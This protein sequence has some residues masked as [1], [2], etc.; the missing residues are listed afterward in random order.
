MAK[1]S[2]R[3]PRTYSPV[4]DRRVLLSSGG[5][6]LL[7]A[8]AI[9]LWAYFGTSQTTGVMRLLAFMRSTF[10]W[11][12]YLVPVVL[13]VLGGLLLQQTSKRPWRWPWLALTG[14]F[15]VILAALALTHLLAD[16][17]TVH[18]TTSKGGVIGCLLGQGLQVLIGKVVAVII[19]L[20]VA[21]AG[22]LMILR[23]PL[24]SV[25]SLAG[26]LIT[27]GGSAG[28]RLAG[29]VAVQVAKLKQSRANKPTVLPPATEALV[30][31]QPKIV[32]APKPAATP[33]K[34]SATPEEPLIQPEGSAPTRN[35]VL[36]VMQQMLMV[37]QDSQMSLADI[38]DK[39]RIIETTLGSLG[40]PAAVTEVNPGPVVTQFGIEPG[41]I[42]RYDRDGKL[43]RSKVKIS[44]IAA[45]SNDLALA[46]AASPI[47]IEAPVPGKSIVGLE[48]P[49]GRL[50]TVGLRGVLESP[51]FAA[52]DSR[53]AM[54]LGRDVSGTAVVADL[55]KLP[56]L[57][58]AGATGSGK[59]VCLNAIIVSLLL[60]NTPDQLKLILVD[61]KRVELTP[62]GGIPHLLSPVVVEP[63]RV[64]GVLNWLMREMDSRY[65]NF[66]AAGAR[67]IEAYNESAAR[68]GEQKLPFIVLI[69]DELADLMIVAPDEVERAVCRLAQMARATGIHLI[70]AT[71][72]P[73]VDVVTGLIKA[74]FPARIAFAVTSQVDSRVILDTPGA[75]KLLGRGD[76]LV[77]APNSPGLT[78]IQGC[79]VSDGELSS[80]VEFWCAQA[81]PTSP[82]LVFD[83]TG[84]T[85]TQPPL[86]ELDARDEEPPDSAMLV[87]AREVVQRSGKAS[88][89][90]LQRNLGIGY[91]RAARLVEQLER[92]GIIGPATGTSK[93]REVI[94]R[95]NDQN[96][97]EENSE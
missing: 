56:H 49:N 92:E 84:T 34:R 33:V 51:E 77:M 87:R 29:W 64:L 73:S 58:I 62:Y 4:N 36:P 96:K 18:C 57:L 74:N 13:G 67:N 69:M 15:M 44:R 28:R 59:S 43:T 16:V 10:G 82:A 46:L 79:F 94:A 66:S 75:E 9:I 12:M 71:Q 11:A 2:I 19:Y 39:A 35:W 42:E 95:D 1:R 63:D 93:P 81:A 6:L 47:R 78:R 38:R 31:H 60:N 41:Y 90:F 45:L 17:Q 65:R 22:V 68:R 61:P 37:R 89:S 91:T 24:A 50:A 5:G 53:L 40:V 14:V 30:I 26:R 80:L 20:V 27:W 83:Q 72:R 70:L 8:G 85:A 32:P 3:R 7:F 25:T 86:L 21:I 88:V 55:V 54:G 76:G 52:L 23:I 97:E 48:V